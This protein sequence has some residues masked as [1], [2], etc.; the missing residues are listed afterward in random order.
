MSDESAD[1]AEPLYDGGSVVA[2]LRDHYHV[3]AL[4]AVM[5]FMFWVR[6]MAFESFLQDGEV[7]FSGN[8]AWYHL[9]EVSYIAQH[10]PRVMPFDPWTYF[11][12]GTSQGQFGT[13]Y[14]QLVATGAMVVGM[15]N[16]SSHTVALTL[17]V[18]PAV[19][20]TLVAVPVYLVTKRLEGRLAGVF[21]A[22]VV[23]FLPGTFLARS[24]VGS[25]DHNAVEPLFQTLGVLATMVALTV[26]A[27]ERPVWEQVVDRDVD[28]LRVT[29][30]WSVLAGVAA[31][32]Y[33]WV[34]PP[35]VLLV[36]ILGVFYVL[37]LTTD[38]LRHTSPEHT[39]FVGAVS[40]TTAG[41]LML[42]PF[43]HFG[44]S[45]TQFSLLQV[46]VPIAVGV[47]TVVVAALARQWDR[48][49]YARQLYPAA[50][51]GLAAVGIAVVS[52]VM[53]KF[54]ALVQNN[55]FR[56]IGFNA[57]AQQRTIVEAAPWL[58]RGDFVPQAFSEYGLTLFT[59]LL[60]S[61]YLLD[62]VARSE[63]LDGDRL[64]VMVWF[65]FILAAAFTQ[66]R[67]NYYLVVPVAVLNGVLFHRTVSHP[68]FGSLRGDAGVNASHVLV[69]TSIVLL[70]VAPVAVGVGAPGD[71]LYVPTPQEVGQRA[72]PGTYQGWQGSLNWLDEHAPAE[73]NYHGA[74]NDDELQ[75]YGT[76]AP[77]ENFDYPAGAYG[78]MSWWDYGHWLTTG[79]G[80]VPTANPFQ[81][82]ATSAANY[83][84]APNTSASAE[85][86]SKIN[87]DDA[88]TR[89][90]AIDWQMVSTSSKFNAPIIFYDRSE[91]TPTEFRKP[92][93]LYS[94]QRVR[95]AAYVKHQRYY[96]STMVRLYRYHGSRVEPGR[97]V[98]DWASNATLRN[99]QTAL[100]GPQGNQSVIRTFNTT[101]AAREYVSTDRT[102]QL[103]GIGDLVPKTI[104]AME[105]Y[106]LVHASET[107]APRYFRT[108]HSAYVKL[109][110]R[111]P[112]ATVEGTGP[113]NA[114]VTAS[115]T[116]NMTTRNQ[117]FTYKQK[118]KTGPDGSFT[119]T[120]P[121]S[122]TDYDEVTAAE[123]YTEPSVRATG[124]YTLST[125][126]V[127]NGTL[128]RWH[129]TLNVSETAVV[130]PDS[131][132]ITV[133][134]ESTNLSIGGG[135]RAPPSSLRSTATADAGT[136]GAPAGDGPV[137]DRRPPSVLGALAGVVDGLADQIA[138]VAAL[139]P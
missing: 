49:N 101:S 59:G 76:Y 115:V 5:A 66:I 106:R 104:P 60:G 61:V 135:D 133:T 36:G 95:R 80:V 134:M 127:G 29:L 70:V 56:F 139:V 17:L 88:K 34:W 94:G 81:Q 4:A 3:P 83:L 136:D 118:V 98:I 53:P 47:G 121:Y 27:R 10:F 39:A 33:M 109:F 110:E 119:M 6:T 84:L 50:V 64:L 114:T 116:M 74:G 14:D 96:N 30:G 97:F 9:R 72:G 132:P 129:S 31:A 7:L 12:Y 25:A 65:S 63:E 85:V 120:L 20:G 28:G 112:G 51:V 45:P 52:V 54:T 82:G 13:L 87:E 89:Y 86:L 117:T 37:K 102:S 93:F 32:A 128:L 105:H 123:G 124:P 43:S 99:G 78:V 77:T 55:L 137:A 131:E 26:A 22:V 40:M 138:P 68:W 75:T 107:G 79:A 90:V 62:D 71:D 21:A 15:G 16:P 92:L 57:G 103:G 69:A 2:L 35:G 125:I 111:V 108:S 67:F 73:G 126:T 42:L 24:T 1:A 46:L 18:A 41:L 58:A 8:D 11:S 91:V 100:L 130:S 19:F 113:E 122:T 23:A 48:R 44:F 38:V